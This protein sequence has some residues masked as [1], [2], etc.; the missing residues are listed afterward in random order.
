M[1]TKV[2]PFIANALLFGERRCRI[3][4]SSHRKFSEPVRHTPRFLSMKL[5]LAKMHT[6]AK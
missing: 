6:G 2:S 1:A 5:C 3:P 4:H